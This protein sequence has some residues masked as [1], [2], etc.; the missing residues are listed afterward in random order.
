MDT[1]QIDNPVLIDRLQVTATLEGKP[2]I[3]LY[4]GALKHPVLQLA[5]FNYG[6]LFSVGIDPNEL[7][8]GQVHY[9]QFLAHWEEGKTNGKGNP[10][11]D[12]VSLQPI[13]SQTEQDIIREL[14][15]IKTLLTFLAEKEA[16]GRDA[17]IAWY[18]NREK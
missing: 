4:S 5:P 2:Q 1:I 3:S 9:C 6:M 18:K 14:N 15:A 8:P 7:Q 12:P 16:G 13:G 17:L 10:Y 11:K